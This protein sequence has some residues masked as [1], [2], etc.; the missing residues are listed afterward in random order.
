MKIKTLWIGIFISLAFFS[1]ESN[2]T[3]EGWQAYLA[4]YLPRF[5]R[6]IPDINGPIKSEELPD[7]FIRTQY[8]PERYGINAKVLLTF[9]L[10]GENVEKMRSLWYCVQS[11]ITEKNAR[12][13]SSLRSKLIEQLTNNG[14]KSNPALTKD[15]LI[16]DSYCVLAN[17][18]FPLALCKLADVFDKGMYNQ[19]ENGKLGYLFSKYGEVGTV[20][21]MREGQVRCRVWWADEEELEESDDDSDTLPTARNS[22]DES[23]DDS[24]TV[25]GIS[26]KIRKKID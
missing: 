23:F 8:T 15:Q 25:A 20:E 6:V 17:K 24:K 19:R 14:Y 3:E 4:G 1:K 9:D 5:S 7:C 22:S 18:G 11:Y 13:E 21:A 12:L 10:S 16:L 2:A 26:Q